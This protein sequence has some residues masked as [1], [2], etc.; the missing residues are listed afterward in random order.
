MT[1]IN[2]SVWQMAEI[3]YFDEPKHGSEGKKKSKKQ[4]D[5]VNIAKWDMRTLWVHENE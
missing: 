3:Y 4:K 1:C 2:Q 5:W